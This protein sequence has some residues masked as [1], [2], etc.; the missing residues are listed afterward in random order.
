MWLRFAKR[1]TYMFMFGQQVLCGICWVHLLKRARP[2]SRTAV[3]VQKREGGIFV[4]GW[5]FDG[6]SW[7]LALNLEIKNCCSWRTQND[8]P[9]VRFIHA[10]AK[11]TIDILLLTKGTIVSFC[12][13][14]SCY[15]PASLYQFWTPSNLLLFYCCCFIYDVRRN[16]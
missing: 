11:S 10:I 5:F 4:S 12:G 13:C 16:C 6:S 9:N 14:N 2:L 15:R 8:K 3:K 1:W 7:G